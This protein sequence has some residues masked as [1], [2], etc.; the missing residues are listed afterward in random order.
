MRGGIAAVVALA[1]ACAT[2]PG[3]GAADPDPTMYCQGD[4]GP[5]GAATE[6]E[7]SV[8]LG[9]PALPT[10]VSESRLT[11]GGVSTRVIQA[12]PADAA[13]AVVFVHGNPGSARDWDDLVAANGKFA[14]TVAFD[15]PGWGKSDKG[16]PPELHT[17]DG[18]AG[19]IQGVLDQLGI[20][21]AV[22]AG[23]DFGGIWGLHWAAQHPDSLLG[24]VLIDS[25]ALRDYVPH[26]LAIVWFTPVVGEAQLAGTTRAAFHQGIQFMQPR[27]LPDAFID[28][29]YDDYDR[30]T[31]CALLRYYRSARDDAL[32]SPNAYADEA[33][34]AL[35]PR[36]LPALVIWGEK[37]PF[38]PVEQ[39]ERQREVF[40]DAQVEVFA[41][42]AHWPF[43]D[44]A[45]R[46]RNAVVPFLRP[47]L[48]ASLRRA[49]AGQRRV[50]VAVKVSGVLPA[51]RVRARVRGSSTTPRTVAGE[52]TL[53]VRLK[54]PLTAGRHRVTVRALGLASQRLVLRVA[55][56]AR[57]APVSN[58]ARPQFTG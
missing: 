36:N 29:M 28:R 22:L 13:E 10:G 53:V 23:H 43:V 8:L 20:R 21:R 11:V 42:S 14:R 33:R 6:A 41:D 17:T 31:R 50:R 37:D 56:L 12:G 38:I 51:Y 46:T 1:I 30:L 45:V 40:P 54:R 18:A 26:A 35:R 19:Y 58:D 32:T 15:I 7:H 25:G 34:E 55:A 4:G 52:Q 39:A 3:A 16:G 2:A 49:R 48:V 24:A 9:D 47:R 57:R 44:N 27:P 5:L